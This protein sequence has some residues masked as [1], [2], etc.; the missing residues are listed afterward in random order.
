MA[1]YRYSKQLY[2]S[3]ELRWE[4]WS[5]SPDPVG[6]KL[7][8][9]QVLQSGSQSWDR[10]ETRSSSSLCSL[11]SHLW[12]RTCLLTGQMHQTPQTTTTDLKAQMEVPITQRRQHA[13]CSSSRLATCCSDLMDR[14]CSDAGASWS[15]PYLEKPKIGQ[16]GRKPNDRWII[17]P[18]NS[19]LCLQ[20]W[21][22]AYLN[23]IAQISGHRNLFWQWAVL[24][25]Y[26]IGASFHHVP[27][28]LLKYVSV[29]RKHEIKAVQNKKGDQTGKVLINGNVT[30]WR[31]CPRQ[32]LYQSCSI[33]V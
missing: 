19:S 3:W 15:R 32:S 30:G 11:Q 33:P 9:L 17:R 20:V 12:K 22:N 8:Y 10:S 4:N 31:L 18:T 16:R 29:P 5:W 23:S 7:I 27:H 2:R 26:P 21:L 1:W 6:K 13:D 24:T 28:K 25:T 14:N